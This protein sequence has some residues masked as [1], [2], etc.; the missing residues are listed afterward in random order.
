MR[1]PRY[2]ISRVPLR[3]LR[4]AKAP[5]PWIFELRT[6][7]YGFGSSFHGYRARMP[8]LAVLGRVASLVPDRVLRPRVVRFVPR[9]VLV[10]M[11]LVTPAPGASCSRHR[12][13]VAAR[14]APT[15][16]ARI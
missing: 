2:S 15:P 14:A 16:P 10:A 8:R 11:G 9:V 13:H 1:W 5:L 12:P 3:M 7:K 4:M 6:S